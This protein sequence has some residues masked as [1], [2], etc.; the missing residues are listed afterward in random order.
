[1]K[2]T[3]TKWLQERFINHP[4]AS[5]ELIQEWFVTAKILNEEEIKCSYTLGQLSHYPSDKDNYKDC[6]DYF[7][8]T[9][10]K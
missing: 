2:Q 7:N 6:V 3:S 10:I 5:P 9:F 4:T 8:K 1:M